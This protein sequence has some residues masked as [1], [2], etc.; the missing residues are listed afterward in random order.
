[1]TKKRAEARR[2]KLDAQI[3]E[4]DIGQMELG[5]D[6]IPSSSP[7]RDISTHHLASPGGLSDD[8][9]GTTTADGDSTTASNQTT[10]PS[11]YFPKDALGGYSSALASTPFNTSDGVVSPRMD[12]QRSSAEWKSYKIKTLLDQC[13]TDRFYV[14]KKLM[15]NSL[16]LT[17]ADIPVK[18]L[19][20]TN[21]GNSLH[22]LSLAGNRLSSIPPELVTCLPLLKSLDL[23][24]CQLHQLPARWNLPQL[25]RLDLS[26]NRLT[27]FPEKV[28]MHLH[29][30][31]GSIRS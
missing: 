28:R 27:D 7:H 12:G 19:N 11:K 21:L 20:G 29:E 1:M 25:K 8:D 23:S 24:Q 13:E 10:T 4:V 14:K 2:W 9:V 30:C 5:A 3:H 6:S 26:H 31:L 18:D 16:D 22:K 15:L 17:V